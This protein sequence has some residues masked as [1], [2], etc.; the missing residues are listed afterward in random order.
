MK[1]ITKLTIFAT[2]L[3]A[4]FAG[5]IGF[6][7]AVD[8][9]V[10]STPSKDH[11][12]NMSSSS[13]GHGGHEMASANSSTAGLEISADGYTLVPFESTMPAQINAALR[14]RIDGTDGNTLTK[15]TKAHEKYLHLII[16]RRDLTG[17]QHLHPT[18][19]T[20]GVWSVPVDFSNPGT[21]RVLADF[22]PKGE[23]D[24]L[25]LGADIFVSGEFNYVALPEPKNT[26]MIDDYE[27]TLDGHAVAGPE[28]TLKL[29]VSYKGKS[30]TDL[31]PY[32]AAYGHL[33]ALR[34][35]DLAY[36]HVHPEG[37]PNDGQTK[38]GPIVKFMA[39]F[40]VAGNYRLYFNFQHKGIVRTAEFTLHVDAKTSKASS[41]NGDKE[42]H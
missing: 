42:G 19:G 39:E 29:S 30:V 41:N 7:A 27:V 13:S 10:S 38:P 33:V 16:V 18:L 11:G 8:P 23:K 40:P 1:S 22:K 25:T 20:D 15:Y 5:A 9:K 31:E 2:V 36:I 35:G 17:F 12:D 28:S 3:V 32:L 14:F 37:E 21:Y 24:S 6:G 26:F 4:I 34:S